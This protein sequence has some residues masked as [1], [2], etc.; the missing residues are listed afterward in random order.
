M[1]FQ[2]KVLFV[3]VGFV[4]DAGVVVEVVIL[5]WRGNSKCLL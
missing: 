4:V 5:G 1:L 2:L 3:S